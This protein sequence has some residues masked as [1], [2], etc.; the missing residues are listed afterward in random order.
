MLANVPCRCL[1]LTLSLALLSSAL[2]AETPRS[3]GDRLAKDRLAKDWP[4]EDWPRSTLAEQGLSAAKLGGLL[5]KIRD[6]DI[7]GQ[8]ALLIVRH[9]YLVLEEYFDGWTADR[10]H[11][12]QS[13]SKS[14]TSALIGIAIEQGAIREVDEKIL[15]FFP[16]MEG[17]QNVDGWKRAMTLKDLLTMRGGTDYH[18]RGSA[19][20][21]D[22]LNSLPRG[23][24][25]FYL[26]RPMVAAPGSKFSYDSGGVILMSALLEARTGLHADAFADRHLLAP[27]KIEKREWF[28]NREGHPHTGGGL[29]VRP[30]DMLKLG[31]LYLRG[32][33]WGEHQVVPEKWVESSLRRHVDWS[34][35]PRGHRVGYGYLWWILEP[36]PAGPGR[37]DIYAAM[38]FRGQYIFIVPEHDMVVAV[39]AGTRSYRDETRAVDFLYSHILPSVRRR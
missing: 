26:D 33:K 3:A 23:W 6:G 27:L 29:D 15:G 14:W 17:I 1:L 20:P 18:E 25:R 11:M 28:R 4:A 39:T 24:D 22:K 34:R 37:Q 12:Q 13:V 2:P 10:V 8:H 5:T 16:E 31:L 30:R 38:G 7:P 36:D 19:S 21:H 9:G 35:D 32:G